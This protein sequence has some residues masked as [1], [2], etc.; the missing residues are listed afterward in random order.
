MS[1]EQNKRFFEEQGYLVVAG[2]LTEQEI[3]A[4]QREVLRLH[5]LAADL[6]A[7][8]DPGAADFQIEPYVE[9]PMEEGLPVLR[10]I[11]QTRKYSD[12]FRDLAGHPGLV[13]ILRNLLGPDLLLFR[14][15]L[16]LKP[17]HHGSVHALHQDSAYWPMRPPTS[18]T[19]SLALTEATSENGCF[20]VIPG[21]HKWPLRDWGLIAKQQEAD[22]SNVEGVDLTGQIEVPLKPGSALFFHSMLVHGSGPNTSPNSRNTALYAYFPPTVDY[23]PQGDNPQPA[24][25]PV[26]SGIEGKS[27]LTLTPRPR[28]ND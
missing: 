18:I 19:L 17:A 15:T 14:S 7:R 10:K 8:N 24:T 27:E 1:P 25:F 13:E 11:E 28:E 6:M 20:R 16:M 26:I 2:I 5:E 22:L 3:R 9:K 12:V 21:S 4:S 23:C